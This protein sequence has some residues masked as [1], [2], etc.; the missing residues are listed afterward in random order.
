MGLIVADQMAS[1]PCGMHSQ[2]LFPFPQKGKE[3]LPINWRYLV[4][5]DLA[6]AVRQTYAYVPIQRREV[7]LKVVRRVIEDTMRLEKCV[8]MHLCGQAERFSHPLHRKATLTVGGGNRFLQQ[9]SRRIRFF[10][11]DQSGELV[12]DV[13]RDP[14]GWTLP[15]IRLVP[16]SVPLR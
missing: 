4:E 6:V 2:L 12:C 8:Y 3:R 9:E 13:H 1:L 11:H 7:P 5:L 14:Y 10:R 15:R 16:R